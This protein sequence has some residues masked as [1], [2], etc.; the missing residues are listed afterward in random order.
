MKIKSRYSIG[1]VILL[2]CGCVLLPPQSPAQV[3]VTTYRYDNSRSGVNSQENLLSP[4]NVNASQFGKQFSQS[5]DGYVFAQPL[6]VPN[7]SLPG[8]GT[9]NVIFVATENDSVYAFD[10]DSNQG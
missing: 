7:L 1:T 5:V 2:L 4:F 3:S 10:A 9:H 8:K 6:Y